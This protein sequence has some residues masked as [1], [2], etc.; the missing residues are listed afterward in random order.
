M[1]SLSGIGVS[2]GVVVGPVRR[3]IQVTSNEPI[4]AT[5]RDVFDALEKVAADL[6]NAAHHIELDIAKDVLGAQA[7][8]AGDPALVEAIGARLTDDRI[9]DDVRADV[10]DSFAGFKAALTALG[11]YFAERTADLDEILNRL[12]AKLSGTEQEALVLTSPSIIVAEDLTPSDTA[13][14]NLQF[15]L[16]LVVAK[17]GPTSHTAIVARGLGIP[18]I[19]GCQGILEVEEGAQLLV[20][21]REG[22]V[23]LNPTSSDIESRQQRE[24]AL[25]ARAAAVVGPGRLKDGTHVTLLANAGDASGA[26]A[27]ASVGTEGIGL[28]RTELLFLDSQT[29]PTVD[30][31]IDM[32][33]SVFS[34][35]K[36]LRV[37]VRTLDA[38]SDKPVPYINAIHEENPALGVRGWRL[39]RTSNDVLNR[40]LQA[41]AAAAEGMDIDLWVMAPMI[42]TPAE[43]QDFATRARALGIKKVGVMIETP[44]AA[45]HADKVLAEVDFGS[46]GTNDLTQYVM[47]S[48]RLDSRLSDMTTTWHPAVL[49]TIQIAC[50]SAKQLSKSTG[51]CGES[52]ANPHLA[53]VLLGL[54]V[55]SLSMA[56][57]AV[58]EVRGF[59]STVDIATCVEAARAAVGASSA[60]AAEALAKAILEQ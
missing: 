3:I 29:E 7:M 32:Y 47:A 54:G 5:P 4:A 35:M 26:I 33:K 59:L 15:A 23:F 30:Q 9:Y 18:A 39:T 36:G 24:A 50:D 1:T 43:A 8:M 31:Q 34:P 25:R 60:E 46:F 2:P 11:G 42:N 57:S 49:R 38:G 28:F 52:A 16:A 58:S 45:I 13:Q 10:T 53:A 40:Q 55:N 12:L 41:I 44:A 48:D 56:P 51:V 19:V 27:A 14:L 17:G 37:V 22:K 6:E 20:D 21:G